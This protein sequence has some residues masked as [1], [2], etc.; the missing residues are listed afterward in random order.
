M[1]DV[2]V[3][4]I[5]MTGALSTKPPAVIGRESASFTGACAL[6]VLMPLC[7]LRTGSFSTGFCCAGTEFIFRKMLTLDYTPECNFLE[8]SQAD[9]SRGH[10]KE[11]RPQR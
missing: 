9:A 3:T 4:S 5:K 8:R 11:D 2:W 10:G 7:W 6:P 1:P